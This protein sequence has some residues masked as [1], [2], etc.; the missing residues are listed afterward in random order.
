MHFKIIIILFILTPIFL[1]LHGQQLYFHRLT[2][3]DGLPHN[4]VNAFAQDK[5]GFMWIASAEGLC[6]F[7]GYRIKIYHSGKSPNTPVNN[8]PA[9][10]YRDDD[11]DVWISFFTTTE[12]CKYNDDK[13]DFT[14]FQLD[15]L[16]SELQKH[17]RSTIG[18]IV[19]EPVTDG[20]HTWKVV[21]HQLV[22]LNN[23]TGERY[24]YKGKA[25]EEGSLFDSY[26]LSIY[27]DD[28]DIL[29]VGTENGGFHYT[30]VNRKK[31]NHYTFEFA[32]S[33]YLSDNAVRV[34]C[35]DNQNFLWVGTRNNGLIRMSPDRSQYIYFNYSPSKKATLQEKRIR[36]IY[37]DSKGVIWVGTQYGVYRYNC[38]TG[39]IKHFV[40]KTATAIDD[41]FVYAIQEDSRGILW[42]GTWK[43]MLS[44]NSETE[45]FV[46]YNPDETL[47]Y[48]SV[49]SIAPGKDGGLW[50][51]TENGL[52]FMDYEISGQTAVNIKATYYQHQE[53]DP[54]SL[55]NDYL[56]ALD[57][58]D[59]G[60]I[61]VG[62]ARG[63]NMYDIS[64][65]Q[66]IHFED[67]EY[68]SNALIRGIVCINDEVWVSHRHGLT[69]LNRKDLTYRHY[70]KS[71]GLQDNEFSEDAYGK[72]TRTGELFFG[73]NNGLNTFFPDQIK[74]NPYPP[75][76]VFTGLKIHNKSVEVHQEVNGKVILENPVFKTNHL[77]FNHT[78]KEFELE[79]AAL[80]YSNPTQNRY[81]Y[82]LEGFDNQWIYTN[83]TR[84][85]VIYSGLSAGKYTLK[86]KGANCDG[87]WNEEPIEMRI[88]ILPPWWA[89]GLAYAI[90]IL[91]FLFICIVIIRNINARRNLKYRMQLEKVKAEKAEE[92]SQLRSTFF[93]GISHELRSPVT[94][95][96][97]PLRK[98]VETQDAPP[99]VQKTYQL[100]YRNAQRLLTLI[101]QLLDFRKLESSKQELHL[102]ESDI[103][104]F[105]KNVLG[106]FELAAQKKNI[107]LRLETSMQSHMLVFDAG[108]LD[109]V[110]VN[111]LSNAIKYSPED[112]M[113][114]VKLLVSDSLFTI[115][116]IDQGIGISPEMKE[117]I[118]DLF[119]RVEDNGK[120]KNIGSGIGLALT[121]ELIHL[122]KGNITV[123]SE[124][125]VGSTFTVLLP[126]A[127]KAEIKISNNNQIS[128]KDAR[129]LL[130]E[131]ENIEENES[132]EEGNYTSDKPL[133][134]VVEDNDDIRD[135]IKESLSNNYRVITA[136]NGK[137][138]WERALETIP[139]LIVSDVMMPEMSGFELC[140]KL[141]KDERTSH[142]PVILLTAHQSDEARMEGYE[143]GADDYI[144]KPFNTQ[145][146][147]IR[148]QNLIESREK[149]RSLFGNATKM[150]L[151]KISVNTADEKFINHAVEVVRSHLADLNFTPDLFASEM[152][153]SRAQLFRKI[154]AMTNQ[155]VQEFIVT[156]RLNEASELLLTTTHTIGEVAVMT[157]FSEASNFTRS[158]TKK[159]KKTP[160]AY[161]KDNS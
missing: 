157:G 74:D 30:D 122:H 161:M 76:M 90:Y 96:I 127:L 138:G 51:A 57:V 17:L 58:D 19:P 82:K 86:V 26:V 159:F 154:K 81:A 6:R 89:S 147:R 141:K 119:F 24:V 18:K 112:T 79:F 150:E 67:I 95:I 145:L 39:D 142:I 34:I 61:W 47:V 83:A 60:N 78:N 23:Q 134:L 88:T 136:I 71:D 124:L 75:K 108:I 129:I 120:N 116:V 44:Y 21:N 1:C 8:R 100:M 68:L 16:S 80:H 113:V 132:T 43:G 52:T 85:S 101:N 59:D 94:L 118:F 146:L 133:I 35:E 64:R 115:Q 114:T 98:L 12:V 65:R 25:S 139:T 2:V 3:D 46:S 104:V 153:V 137:L 143:T 20:K 10:L 144:S 109:K 148:I 125:G 93:T 73:G 121:R 140:G 41:N 128:E 92:V 29:W 49:R 99:E 156:I 69:R 28:N 130:M 126:N 107:T 27:L 63:L 158:F 32:H 72:N 70:D 131:T 66:F 53:G 77:I 48:N 105:V 40:D 50:I 11:G 117:K 45:N 135:Y 160:S 15:E 91:L 149:L 152:A 5:N 38:L 110:L 37:Q 22:Q 103:I 33:D 87:V 106:M 102:H 123:D 54:H 55:N 84:R 9:N 31:F 14:R 13:D 111:L 151:K 42:I 155:T 97:D 7:D 4:T 56:Y 36:K 62:T